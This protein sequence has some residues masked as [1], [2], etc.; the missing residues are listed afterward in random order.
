MCAYLYLHL[1]LY[2]YIYIYIYMCIFFIDINIYI[3]Y[4]YIY[5]INSYA[6]CQTTTPL[7]PNYNVVGLWRAGLVEK[8][9]TARRGKADEPTPGSAHK[10]QT[11]FWLPKH[12]PRAQT[13]PGRATH[14]NT[15]TRPRGRERAAANPQHCNWGKGGKGSKHTYI[16]TY[17]HTYIHTLI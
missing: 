7:S 5:I 6:L 16:H 4:I 3:T 9:R 17:M 10:E 1:Y 13:F 8:E 12:L 15:P 11:P 2:L 14:A